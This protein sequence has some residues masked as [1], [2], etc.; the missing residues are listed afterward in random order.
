MR[1]HAAVAALFIVLAILMTWPLARNLERA[2][3]DPGDPYVN[4]WVLDWGYWSTIHHPLSLFHAN[5]FHPSRYSLAFTENLYG[6]TLLLI[7]ARLA[8]ATPMLAHNLAV[9]A[10]FA[11]SGFAAYLLGRYVSGSYPAGLAA[12]VFYAFVPF[13]F[14]H[15]PHVQ[16]IWGGWLPLLILALLFYAA[17]PSWKRAVL[18]GAVFL[19]NGLTNIHWLLFGSVAIA[20]TALL[21]S[22]ALPRWRPL[23]A[24]TA[25]SMVLLVPFLYPYIAVSK[26]YGMARTPGDAMTYS[27]TPGDWLVS[28]GENRLYRSLHSEAVDPE[29]R[30]FPGALGI[31]LAAAGLVALRRDRRTVSVALLWILLGFIGSLGLNTFFHTFLYDYVPGFKA[32]RATARWAAIA[33]VGMAM[34]IALAVARARL[35]AWIVPLLFVAELWS[36][37]IRWFIASPEPPPVYEWLAREPLRGAVLELPIDMAGSEYVYLLRSAA[38]H[39]PLVN[40]PHRRMDITG[41]WKSP[42]IPDAFIGVLRSIG[43]EL[44]I[45]HNDYLGPYEASTHEWIAREMKRGR[46]FFVRRFDGG[47]SGDWV[48]SL[49]RGASTIPTDLQNSD[50]FGRFDPPPR[51]IDGPAFFTGFALSPHGIRGVDLLFESGGVRVPAELFEDEALSTRF[52][53]YPTGKP[54]FASGLSQRPEGVRRETDVQPEIIDGRGVRKRLEHYWIDWN[55][56]APVSSPAMSDNVR[57]SKNEE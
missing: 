54:R 41:M 43:C 39:K 44:I 27:A 50:T 8:G 32:I 57:K 22:G 9:L 45:V 13:R 34:L 37:P 14:T 23:A 55:D 7:P 47:V 48:F 21:L 31:A 52:P 38:H 6:I 18:F 16:H 28:N 35:G 51:V 42:A 25:V 53:G 49:E 4:I 19:M 17:R 15:R 26:L 10:G 20:L 36:A 12:G 24:A 3:A 11:F 5:A 30:L 46:L 29:R 40:P 1:R 2:V 33:H 56:A